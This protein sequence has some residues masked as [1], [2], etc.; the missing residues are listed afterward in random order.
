MQL[1]SVAPRE[2][3]SPDGAG[4]YSKL[5]NQILLGDFILDGILNKT[6][7]SIAKNFRSPKNWPNRSALSLSP[8]MLCTILSV[9]EANFDQYCFLIY[10][11]ATVFC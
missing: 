10:I 11:Y 4:N 7:N 1:L 9:E 6:G 3:F 2:L 8:Q 5:D